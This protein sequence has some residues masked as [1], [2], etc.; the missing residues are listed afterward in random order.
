M[1]RDT[2]PSI[3]ARSSEE[4][5]GTREGVMVIST[6]TSKSVTLPVFELQWN[7]FLFIARYNFHDWKLSVRAPIRVELGIDFHGLFKPDAKIN[8]VYC[9]GFSAEWVYGPYSENQR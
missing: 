3:L 8:K 4:F 7:D 9:E 5:R 2:L 6:H 1:F